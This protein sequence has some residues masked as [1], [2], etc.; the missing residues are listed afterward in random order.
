MGTLRWLIHAPF[1][2]YTEGLPDCLIKTTDGASRAEDGSFEFPLRAH[3]ATSGQS[4][5]VESRGR[6]SISAYEG[7]LRVDLINPRL[8]L[9]R[10]SGQLFTEN[11]YR[12][13]DFVLVAELS[14]DSGS[15]PASSEPGQPVSAVT[16]LTSQGVG[17]LSDGRYPPGQQAAPVRWSL[18][19]STS[20]SG[21]SDEIPGARP[22]SAGRTR[23]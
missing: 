2:H 13:A 15:W 23:D 10:D 22:R 8:E 1:L 5:V 19:D 6:V 17:W 3:S 21:S 9:E 12:E 14:S 18:P 16:H 7:M 20:I 11:P 4:T